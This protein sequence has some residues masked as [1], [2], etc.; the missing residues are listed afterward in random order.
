LKLVGNLRQQVATL[1]EQ[2]KTYYEIN[3]Q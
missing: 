3:K 1:K 2:V